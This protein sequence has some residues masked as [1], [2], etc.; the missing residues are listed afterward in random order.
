MYQN[1]QT[2]TKRI[3]EPE[4]K[5]KVQQGMV[6]PTDKL[7]KRNLSGNITDALVDGVYL[8][9]DHHN[10]DLE[11]CGVAGI[12]EQEAVIEERKNALIEEFGTKKKLKD[13]L[14]H[15]KRVRAEKEKEE[16]L[17]AARELIAKEDKKVSKDPKKDE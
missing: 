17:N 14:E 15:E 13:A 4:T 1:R 9:G 3:V 7:I 2:W 11:K 6:L 5:S 12:L 16:K 10:V 8:G